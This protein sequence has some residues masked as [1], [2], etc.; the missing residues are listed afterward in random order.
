[1][2]SGCR[3]NLP[4][5]RRGPD[6]PGALFRRSRNGKKIG[7]P[8]VRW[9]ERRPDKSGPAP[10]L[11]PPVPRP[12]RNGRSR[13]QRSTLQSRL[14]VIVASSRSSSS[15]RQ[16]RRRPRAKIV[17]GR[18]IGKGCRAPSRCSPRAALGSWRV[19]RWPR[20][21]PAGR[22]P[23]AA[24]RA[25]RRTARLGQPRSCC[26]RA[27]AWGRSHSRFPATRA[28]PG[29]AAICLLRQ[30]HGHRQRP[31]MAMPQHA[32]PSMPPACMPQPRPTTALPVS[33]A[34]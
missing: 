25:T 7:R 27:P 8:F 18:G 22:D 15:R 28:Q 23:L 13:P 26:C 1:M 4:L 16:N 34:S 19:K 9:P 5:A 3:T 12:K 2:P 32:C 30:C 33:P 31:P 29:C 17:A 14:S 20:P 10:Q 24:T 11:C 6:I 21:A